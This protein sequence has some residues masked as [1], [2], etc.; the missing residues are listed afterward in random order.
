LNVFTGALS[1]DAT[2]V[3]THLG[4]TRFQA[5]GT[6]VPTGAS[7]FS[8]SGSYTKVAANGDHLFGTF[9]GTGVLT[10]T[11]SESIV[12]NTISGGTGRF[13]GAGGTSTS[14]VRS[15]TISFDGVTVVTRAEWTTTGEISY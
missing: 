5:E 8:V 3:E 7:T 10:P 12:H 4:N 1:I 11:G 14:T 9:T 13:E 15:T 2:E 6:L